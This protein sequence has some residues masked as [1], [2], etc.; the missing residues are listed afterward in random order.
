MRGHVV[1]AYNRRTFRS[2]GI[3]TDFVQDNQ[4]LSVESGIIRGLHYQIAPAAQAKLVRVLSGAIRDVVVDLRRHSQTFGKHLS[5]DLNAD[6]GR[7]ILVPVG[8]AH[9]Y[10]SLEPN[11]CVLY[12]ISDYYS[13]PHERGI[14]W[15]DPALEIDWGVSGE[16]ALLSE[17]DRMLPLLK[18]AGDLF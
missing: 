5:T 6:D 18:D 12:K 13:P 8:F 16:N 10:S 15:D 4:S 7:Q 14:R 1:E 17:R 11:T 3:S 9:G 2:L